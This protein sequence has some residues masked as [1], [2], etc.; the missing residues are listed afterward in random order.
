MNARINL[1]DSLFKH[2]LMR[3]AEDAWLAHQPHNMCLMYY[4][5]VQSAV[6]QHAGLS[7]GN[8][9]GHGLHLQVPKCMAPLLCL[10]L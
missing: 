10:L 8:Y 5:N 1:C 7:Q 6:I 2:G 3:R 9:E 4:C